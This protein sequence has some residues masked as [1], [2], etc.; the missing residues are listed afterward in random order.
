[1]ISKKK[2]SICSMIWKAIE[3][4]GLYPQIKWISTERRY[5][6]LQMIFLTI[7]NQDI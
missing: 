2:Y 5:V 4:N 6:H 7:N 3:W 1:M